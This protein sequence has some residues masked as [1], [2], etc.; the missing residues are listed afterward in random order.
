MMIHG[1]A[2]RAGQFVRHLDRH[3]LRRLYGFDP[4]HVNRLRDRPYALAVI[5]FLNGLPEPRRGSVVEIRRPRA[6]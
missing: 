1:W 4:W 6:S 3:L 5:A 2:K